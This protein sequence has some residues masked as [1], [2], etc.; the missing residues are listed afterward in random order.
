[1]RSLKLLMAVAAVLA[2]SILPAGCG[3]SDTDAG[4]KKPGLPVTVVKVDQ[5]DI[6]DLRSYPGNTEAVLEAYMVARVEGFLEE[7]HFEEGTDVSA[8]DLLFLIQQQ[9]YEAQVLQAQAEVLDAEVAVA[10][11]RTEYE[12][13]QPLGESGAISKQDWD[14]YVRNLESAVAQYES[15]QANLI[16]ARINFSYTEV[17]APFDGRIGRRLVDVGNLVGPGQNENLALLV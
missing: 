5:R 2:A 12:R 8:K 3:S 10:Y 9:P 6:P 4:K 11:A 14:G 15:T 1:M 17:R 16:M 7:R 13:N